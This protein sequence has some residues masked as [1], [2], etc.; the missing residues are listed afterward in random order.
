MA[1]PRHSQN[2]SFAVPGV[3]KKI[4][5]NR[6]FIQLFIL[7]ANRLVAVQHIKKTKTLFE[8]IGYE[9]FQVFGPG[10]GGNP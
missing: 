1:S 2:R 4:T 3:P 8:F 7:V 10:E 9:T 6:P 5:K